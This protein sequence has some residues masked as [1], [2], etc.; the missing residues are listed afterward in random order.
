MA[1]KGEREEILAKNKNETY[2][3]DGAAAPEAVG[4]A[5]AAWGTAAET[6][7]T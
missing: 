2:V 3:V 7:P 5:A 6:G 1:L 4:G